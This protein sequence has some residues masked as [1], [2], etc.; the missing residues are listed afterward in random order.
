VCEDS[1]H[2]QFLWATLEKMSQPQRAKFLHFCSGFSRLPASITDLALKFK[3]APPPPRSEEDPDAFLPIAQTCFFSL[4]LPAYT[5]QA[6]C[7]AKLLYAIEHADLMDA[8]FVMRSA[9]GW[10]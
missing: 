8:D 5:S 6:V 1:K 2:V 4:S 9:E 10:E 3:I 7:E